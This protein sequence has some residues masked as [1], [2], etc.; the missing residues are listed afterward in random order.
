VQAHESDQIGVGS[1][2]LFIASPIEAWAEVKAIEEEAIAQIFQRASRYAE[3]RLRRRPTSFSIHLYAGETA[4]ERDYKVVFNLIRSVE[5][6]ND[7]TFVAL[8]TNY[9]SDNVIRYSAA[10]DQGTYDFVAVTHGR[11]LVIPWHLGCPVWDSEVRVVSRDGTRT[12]RLTDYDDSIVA[13][14]RLYTGAEPGLRMISSANGAY[15][16]TSTERIRRD[17]DRANKQIS[18]VVKSRPAPG[19]L[20]LVPRDWMITRQAFLTALLG[21][22]TVTFATSGSRETSSPFYGLNGVFRPNHHRHLSGCYLIN[23]DQWTFVRNPFALRPI[24]NLLAAA[25]EFDAPPGG[26]VR[27]VDSA[28]AQESAF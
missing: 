5:S 21:D 24:T 22:L 2:D 25:Q 3:T 12:L 19:L 4:N 28:K 6:L 10:T 11:R 26:V 23:G 17:A 7:E 18:D 13:G 14:A 15:P 16:S 27:M 8:N 1:P 9:E 20:F